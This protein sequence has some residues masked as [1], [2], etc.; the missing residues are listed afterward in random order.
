M[1]AVELWY[2][3]RV[4]AATLFFDGLVWSAP[5]LCLA[6]CQVSYFQTRLVDHRCWVDWHIC[7]LPKFDC[8]VL[9]RLCRGFALCCRPSCGAVYLFRAKRRETQQLILL[10]H[11]LCVAGRR[12]RDEVCGPLPHEA[13]GSQFFLQQGRG[14]AVGRLHCESYTL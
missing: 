9:I 11:L 8:S 12:Q 13:R 10:L 5:K 14:G 1:H 4:C 2:S 3:L 7:R 6:D